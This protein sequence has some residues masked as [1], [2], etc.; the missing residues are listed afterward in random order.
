MIFEVGQS[1][2]NNIGSYKVLTIHKDTMDVCY[3]D[4]HR[5]TLSIGLQSR[6]YDNYAITESTKRQPS[7][8]IKLIEHNYSDY[9]TLGFLLSRLIH[10]QHK[11]MYDKQDEAKINYFDITGQELDTVKTGVFYY[12]EGANQWGNQGV[13]TF[14]ANESELLLLK[15]NSK[16]TTVANSPNTYVVSDINYFYFMLKNNFRLGNKQDKDIIQK[17]IPNPYI[18]AFNK[19]YIYA[20]R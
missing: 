4:G 18:D 12:R 6:I 14:H 8:V 2:K 16:P 19:G 9:W 5:Q 15:F 3:A 1:Y 11:I 20:Q 7:K 17:S 10:L 13:I